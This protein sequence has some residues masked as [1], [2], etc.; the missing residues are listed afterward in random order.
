[1]GPSIDDEQLMAL[2]TN[3][4]ANNGDL[5]LS[6]DQLETMHSVHGLAALLSGNFQLKYREKTTNSSYYGS[7]ALS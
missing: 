6:D 3:Y 1:M 4:V 5:S 2:T 7:I